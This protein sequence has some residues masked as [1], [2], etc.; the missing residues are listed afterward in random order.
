MS[1]VLLG[2]TSG[3]ITLQ[4]P[5]VAGTTVLDLPATSGTVMISGNM[6][7]FSA[8]QA[9]A[10][11]TSVP[12]ATF[13]KIT[14]D[15]EEFDTANCFASSRFTP[16]VAG[17]Y[18]INGNIQINNSS[19]SYNGIVSIFKNG[20]RYK[21]GN[22]A[23]LT[24]FSSFLSVSCLVYLNGSTDYVELYGYQNSGGTLTSNGG[25]TYSYLTGSLVR[26][27]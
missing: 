9:N 15:A 27:A 23:P 11:N 10:T 13:T 8:Y 19:T 3:S 25:Q 18:Q 12:S 4:E 24:S 20:S 2:S 1:I 5:A 7:A 16:N 6:P 21:D 17:Y 26:N 14:L 22:Y